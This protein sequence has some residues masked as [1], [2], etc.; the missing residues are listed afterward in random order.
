MDMLKRQTLHLNICSLHLATKLGQETIID[1]Y[2]NYSDSGSRSRNFS[3]HSAS[4]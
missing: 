4:L 2:R 3:F 1:I